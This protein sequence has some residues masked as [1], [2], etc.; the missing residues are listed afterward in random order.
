MVATRNMAQGIPD[1]LYELEK[2]LKR[3]AMEE[4]R[5]KAQ[6]L[7][8]GTPERPFQVGDVVRLKSGGF[9]MVVTDL[10]RLGC[11]CEDGC[12]D[13]MFASIDDGALKLK[14][15]HFRT[16]CVELAPTFDRGDDDKPF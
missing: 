15:A 16:V 2:R 4:T 9:G 3:K 1:S 11:D 8:D 5:N 12:V 13:V 10:S 7:A 14:R 6:T